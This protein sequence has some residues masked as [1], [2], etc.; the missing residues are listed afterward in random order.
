MSQCWTNDRV[1]AWAGTLL[2]MPRVTDQ[3]RRL[4]RPPLTVEVRCTDRLKTGQISG[5]VDL[6]TGDLLCRLPPSGEISKPMMLSFLTHEVAHMMCPDWV[7]HGPP[8]RWYWTTVTGEVLETELFWPHSKN[9]PVGELQ[10]R[11]AFEAKIDTTWRRP[12][13]SRPPI[14]KELSKL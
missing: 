4:K 14:L 12:M 13:W 8:W 7:S 1:A 9:R 10:A 5:Y 3:W 2:K 11:S 6:D